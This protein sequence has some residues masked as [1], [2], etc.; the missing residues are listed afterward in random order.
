MDE[1]MWVTEMLPILM[2]GWMC[3]MVLLPVFPEKDPSPWH[4][5]QAHPHRERAQSKH[6]QVSVR[7]R[8]TL[9]SR[10]I[11]VRSPIGGRDHTVKSRSAET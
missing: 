5:K 8:E 3:P 10:L 4:Q 11:C 2:Q 1:F 6:G 7:R 9:Q